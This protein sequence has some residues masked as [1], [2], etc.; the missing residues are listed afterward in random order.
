VK[1]LVDA[2]YPPVVADQL[3]R[4]GHDAIAARA[5]AQLRELSDLALIVVARA[6]RLVI[7]TENTRDFLILDGEL[8]LRG[9][10]H[11]GFIL[12]SARSYPRRHHAGVGRLVTALDAWLREHPD[13]ADESSL[14]WWL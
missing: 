12:V 9:E 10:P 2:M 7:V 5:S 3:R 14:I 11:C 4:R 8:R 1:L 6:E 13:E